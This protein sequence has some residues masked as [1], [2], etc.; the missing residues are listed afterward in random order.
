MSA[1]DNLALTRRVFEEAWN[2]GNLDVLD[3][4]YSTNYISHDP[5]VPGGALNRDAFKQTIAMYRSAF[6]DVHFTIDE[7]YA[8]G[9]SMVVV[10]WTAVGTHTGPLQ[11]MPATGKRSTVTGLTL[12]RFANGKGVEDYTNWDTLG[13]LQQIGAIPA[14][15]QATTSAETRPTAQ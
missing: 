9:D 12:A 4:M 8:V 15:A 3:E 10:R 11:G 1:E 7:Q 13:M 14:M 2:K 5:S 6:P